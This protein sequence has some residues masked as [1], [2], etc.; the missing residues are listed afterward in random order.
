MG[1][2]TGIEWADHTFNHIIGCQKVSPAC[3]M[4]YAETCSPVNVS[5][6][7]GL[8]LWGPPS[9]GAVRR[10]ASRRMFKQPP[11]WNA[12]AAKAGV[13]RRV[14]CASLADVFEA[15]TGRLVTHE[16]HTMVVDG[17]TWARM[18]GHS[19][20]KDS[21]VRL[22][23]LDDVRR[24]LFAIIDDTQNLVW[25]LLTKRPE[26]I[27]KMMPT[28]PSVRQNVWLGTTA[29]NQEEADR[30]IPELIAC[31]AALRFLSV[32]PLLGQVDLSRHLRT[33][34]IGW[35][36]VGG[37]SG[38]HDARPMH[39]AWVRLIQ[40]QCRAFG[41]PFFFKQ[42][43]QWQPFQDNRKHEAARLMDIRGGTDD[44]CSPAYFLDVGKD[45]AG[46]LLAASQSRELKIY[47]E[48]PPC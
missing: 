40:N 12:A 41:V 10:V 23:T 9:T 33:G 20:P 31:P 39:P 8:E 24:H 17:N 11:Y 2:S 3:K 1:I 16:G 46:N 6:K 29:E 19:Y 32:E 38:G 48:V 27:Q 28:T 4:C 45:K 35:V 18:E 5:R 21:N 13:R 14:F 22:L 26:N 25:M 15:Y 43:G 36:I 7:I 37:E 44:G 30:R 34:K 47:Q 42:W